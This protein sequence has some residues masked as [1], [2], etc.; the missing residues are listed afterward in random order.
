MPLEI[1]RAGEHQF[2]YHAGAGALLAFAVELVRAPEARAA[3]RVQARTGE[4]QGPLQAR[5]GDQLAADVD[6]EG[7][8]GGCPS[9]R[10]NALPERP[11]GNLLALCASCMSASPPAFAFHPTENQKAAMRRSAFG[12]SCRRCGRTETSPISLQSGAHTR[13]TDLA[14]P[15][16]APAEEACPDCNGSPAT[17]DP[18]AAAVVI[19]CLKQNRGWNVRRVVQQASQAG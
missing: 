6:A 4:A 17:T 7:G 15:A 14:V 9:A 19:R 13:Y 8:G 12:W 2:L 18:R 10:C 16:R 5:P 3:V 1:S 11:W